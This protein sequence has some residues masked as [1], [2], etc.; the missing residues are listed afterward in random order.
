MTRVYLSF[1]LLREGQVGEE[2]EN[3]K[4][5]RDENTKKGRDHKAQISRSRDLGKYDSREYTPPLH[6]KFRV[7]DVR[8]IWTDSARTSDTSTSCSSTSPAE[9][10]LPI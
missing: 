1:R 3:V 5:R 8:S 9:S 10:S 6:R 4:V 7:R 2:Q